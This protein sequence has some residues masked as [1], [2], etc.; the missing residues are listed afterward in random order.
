MAGKPVGTPHPGPPGRPHLHECLLRQ[1]RGL[2]GHSPLQV[3]RQG[4][5]DAAAVAGNSEF[6]GNLP[7]GPGHQVAGRGPS[8][9][10][11]GRYGWD[12]AC[13]ARP[14]PGPN[15][16]LHTKA[17]DASVSRPMKPEDWTPG[18]HPVLDIG[19]SLLCSNPG[20]GQ[21][22]TAFQVSETKRLATWTGPASWGHPCPGPLWASPNHLTLSRV[23]CHQAAMVAQSSLT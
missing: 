17:Y 13:P 23:Q 7:T 8:G 4:V 11:C 1:V 10:H 22:S 6:G 19:R 5:T 20:C 3:G 16:E 18:P 14:T 9:A 15:P 12:G 21:H 2:K